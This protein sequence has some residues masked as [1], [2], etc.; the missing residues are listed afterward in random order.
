MNIVVTAVN[1]APDAVD[2]NI[3]VD[4]GGTATFTTL[5]N[6]SLLDNDSDP[7]GSDIS[8]FSFTQPDYGTL[9]IDPETGSFSY[10]HDGTENFTDSFEYSI[11]DGVNVSTASVSIEITPQNDN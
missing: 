3:V 4:E 8:I 7:D 11:T 2:D 5:G 6:S 1:Q 9:E 10:A